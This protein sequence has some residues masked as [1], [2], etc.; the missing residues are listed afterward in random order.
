[1]RRAGRYNESESTRL[2]QMEREGVR[3]MKAKR[4]ENEKDRQRDVMLS[5]LHVSSPVWP[6]V[7]FLM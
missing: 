2:K 4:C 1:M 6:C 5:S 3:Q 7:C